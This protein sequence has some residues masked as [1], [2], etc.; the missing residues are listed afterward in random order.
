MH[1]KKKKKNG[2]KNT[3]STEAVGPRNFVLKNKT[4]VYPCVALHCLLVDVY[5]CVGML[6]YPLPHSLHPTASVHPKQVAHPHA[7]P[8]TAQLID[9]LVHAC[10]LKPV[11]YRS[12]PA[13][14]WG[15]STAGNRARSRFTCAAAVR[16]KY[17]GSALSNPPHFPKQPP[18]I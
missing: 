15:K 14:L 6:S 12:Q 3:H 11:R 18:Q 1:K 10:P 13:P 17:G 5:P 16:Y 9:V 4:D 2:N 8:L 7:C